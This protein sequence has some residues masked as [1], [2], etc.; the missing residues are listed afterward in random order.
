MPDRRSS[1]SSSSHANFAVKDTKTTHGFS[2]TSKQGS[3]ARKTYLKIY[4]GGTFAVVIL[5]FAVFSIF[6]GALWKIPAR[7]LEGWVIDFDGDFIGK[8]IAEALTLPNSLSAVTWTVIS[9]SQF[10]HGPSDVA[11]ALL[12]EQTWAAITI[13]A[14]S[15]SRLMSSLASPNSSYDGSEAI[16]VFGV[17]A[18]NENALYFPATS[19]D[20]IWPSAQA[21]LDA[22]SGMV[23][24]QVAKSAANATNLAMVLST[25]PQ[26]ITAPV[27]Y[28]LQ[29]LRPFNIPVATAVTFVGLIYQLI[30]SFFIVMVGLSAREASGYDRNLHTRSLIVLRLISSFAAYF[31]ISLFYALLSV[32][33]QLPMDH[34]FGHAGFVLFWM[35]NYAGMLACGLALESMITLLTARGVPFFML[36]WII[37]NVSVCVFPLEVMP[38]IFNYGHAA[39]FYNVSRAMRTIIFGTKNR[40]SSSGTLVW[41][42]NRLDSNFLHHPAHLPVVDESLHEDRESNTEGKE[43]STAV[44]ITQLRPE[45]NDADSA[46]NLFNRRFWQSGHEMTVARATYFKILIPGLI[47]VG[48]TILAIFSIFW[49]ALWKVPAHP[50]PGWLVDLDGGE[51]G[52]FVT[53]SLTSAPASM[54]SW[55]TLPPNRFSKGAIDVAEEIKNDGAWVA[56][57]INEG[58]STRLKASISDPNLSYV[59]ADAIT[60]YAAEARNENAYDIL[61]QP[62]LQSTLDAIQLKAAIHFASKIPTSANLSAVLNISP[63]TIINPVSYRIVNLI[64]FSQPV[65]IAAVFVG[66]I[67]V[68]IMSFFCV[69]IANGARE[70]SRLNKLLSVKS[71]I[72]LRLTSS[73]VAYFFLSLIYSLLNLAFQLDLSHTY[74]HAGFVVFW[75][76]NWVY[77]TAVGLALESLVTI[78][79]QFIP[80]FL[81]TWIV[82]NV[83]VTFFP[84]ELL[85]KIFHYGYAMPFYNLSNAVRHLVFGT[86]NH[87]GLN[88]GV[89][90]SWVAVSCITLTLF[91]YHV[92]RQ[93]VKIL[94]AHT[95]TAPKEGLE[96]TKS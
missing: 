54:V 36:A 14:G 21:S 71:L 87:L 88:F 60:A 35:L 23:A 57:V 84:V 81:I 94:Q 77:M 2:D 15:T 7:N 48:L 59:G 65:A 72:L 41:N 22:I 8:D 38:K 92:R 79:R 91:Q 56:I 6:W 39:P 73:F 52:Q 33:F 55:Q 64:P 46:P 69:L 1:I 44:S 86:K 26:S 74:G 66:L 75:I 17:E 82:V 19:R 3:I 16:T 5:I 83:S 28:Q 34:R 13:N 67:F 89:L 95:H 32:A 47:L 53:E 29:N 37:T 51:I 76:F 96:K 27:S 68:L 9:P 85:P 42:S 78:L 10:P 24:I 30:L 43:G 11:A 40:A 20:L 80:F 45:Q 90:L 63:E 50:F 25:S 49:G 62:Y 61:L 93:D 18:R 12:D 31:F 58:A 70:A 4:A